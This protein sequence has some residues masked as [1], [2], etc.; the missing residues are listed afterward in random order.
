MHGAKHL[1]KNTLIFF[2][3]NILPWKKVREGDDMETCFL[4]LMNHLEVLEIHF[5]KVSGR[6][7][8]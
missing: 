8:I 4:N 3:K 1:S 7:K 5:I 2:I 6:R